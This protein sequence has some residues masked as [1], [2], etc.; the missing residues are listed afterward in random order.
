MGKNVN[1]IANK[2]NLHFCLQTI[3]GATIVPLNLQIYQMCWRN[4]SL[5]N[6]WVGHKYLNFGF[7]CLGVTDQLSLKL[8]CFILQVEC[9]PET[10]YELKMFLT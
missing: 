3:S 4:T 8:F 9:S 7:A 2:F 5:K 1:K 6:L 10:P